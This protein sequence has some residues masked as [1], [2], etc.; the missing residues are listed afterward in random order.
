M[1]GVPL[2][3]YVVGLLV[4]F[5]VRTW[6]HVRRTGTSGF[7]GISR[8]PGSLRWWAGVLFVLALAL[9]VV[10]L[11]LAVTRAVPPPDLPP[12]VA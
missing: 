3:L 10:A 11:A 8:P 9:G 12:A 4:L 2:V 7:S 1:S 5:G 6:L